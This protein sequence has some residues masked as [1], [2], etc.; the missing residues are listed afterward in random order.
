MVKCESLRINMFRI[1]HTGKSVNFPVTKFTQPCKVEQVA[2]QHKNQRR[3]SGNETEK[4]EQMENRTRKAV[5]HVIKNSESH[6]DGNTFIAVLQ[7][8]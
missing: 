7:P 3:I 8:S 4:S 5:K 1:T 2:L 6:T